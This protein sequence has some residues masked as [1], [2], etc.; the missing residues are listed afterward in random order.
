[1]WFLCSY[2]EYAHDVKTA[3]YIQAGAKLKVVVIIIVQRDKTFR[4]STAQLI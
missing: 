3:L 4:I 1:M 2:T